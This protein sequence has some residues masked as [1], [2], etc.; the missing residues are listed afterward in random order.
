MYIRPRVGVVPIGKL[1]SD[2]IKQDFE[3]IKNQ[4]AGAQFESIVCDPVYDEVDVMNAAE[5]MRKEDLDL[6][7]LVPLQGGSAQQQVL[8]AEACGIF[9]LIWSLPPRFSMPSGAIAYG[10]L[11]ERGAKIKYVFGKAGAEVTS[12]I[13]DLARVAFAINRLRRSRIGMV[14]RVL[15]NMVASDFDG[16]I[17]RSRLG[18]S[19][20]TVNIADLQEALKSIEDASLERAVNTLGKFTVNAPADRVKDAMR[21]HLAVK[22]IVEERRLDAIAMDCWTELLR[23]FK[24]TPCMGYIEDAY[25]IGCEGD[26]VGAALLLLIRYLTDKPAVLLDVFSLDGDVLVMGGMC[27]ASA[28]IAGS[29]DVVVCDMAVPPMF[30][31]KERVVA[32]RPAI[33]WDEVTLLRISGKNID[34]VHM[35]HG[36]VVAADRRDFVELKIRLSGD[37]EEFLGNLH[38]HLY[39][40]VPGNVRKRMILLCEWLGLRLIE[41]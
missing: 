36:K 38:G 18:P 16:N 33:S 29:S 35:V 31:M 28:S 25:T 41:S 21:M 4:V 39:A 10:A 32:V 37:I 11:V 6:L 12:K 26:A 30:Q 34:R 7:L 23:L 2:D 5:K 22:K 15:P 3:E 40:V 19:V 24:I 1:T 9:T 8:A 14:G 20:V 17:L 27:S 13:E